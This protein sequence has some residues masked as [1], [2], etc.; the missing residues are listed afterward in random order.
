MAQNTGEKNSFEIF[1]KIIDHGKLRNSHEKPVK[2]SYVPELGGLHKNLEIN[3]KRIA[4]KI[5]KY[6]M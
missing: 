3:G 6:T 5:S 1:G 4:L 2:F